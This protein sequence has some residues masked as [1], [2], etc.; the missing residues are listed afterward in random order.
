MK[1][2]RIARLKQSK[3][4]RKVSKVVTIGLL[5]CPLTLGAINALADTETTEPVTEEVTPVEETPATN[6]EIAPV[7]GT[8][9][10]EPSQSE[11]IEEIQTEES[12]VIEETLTEQQTIETPVLTEQLQE[13]TETSQAV[14]I[15][16][17]YIVSNIVDDNGN[18]I[19]TRRSPETAVKDS[20]VEIK[21][22]NWYGYYL[23]P[24]TPSEY[25]AQIT[26]DD[27]QEFV[28]TY[29]SATSEKHRDPV[30]DKQIDDLFTELYSLHGELVPKAQ[31]TEF[32]DQLQ[33]IYYKFDDISHIQG[34]VKAEGGLLAWYEYSLPKLPSILEE[35]KSLAEK[36]N[37]LQPETPEKTGTYTVECLAVLPGDDFQSVIFTEVKTAPYGTTIR[38]DAPEI[39]GYKLWLN[40]GSGYS[41]PFVNFTMNEEQDNRKVIF[42]YLVDDS[43]SGIVLD[44]ESAKDVLAK[45][46]A[47]VQSNYT[48]ESW[49]NLQDTIANDSEINWISGLREIIIGNALASQENVDKAV[50]TV[51]DAIS[52]LVEVDPISLAEELAQLQVNYDKH[53]SLNESDYTPESWGLYTSWV[54][55]QW[56]LDKG[57]ET[58]LSNPE[59]APG[60]DVNGY[61]ILWEQA[62]ALLVAKDDNQ[63][64]GGDN[65]DNSNNGGNG[66]D[67]TDNSNNQNGNTNQDENNNNSSNPSNTN[68]NTNKANNQTATNNNTKDTTDLPQTGDT[69][70]NMIISG[71]TMLGASLIAIL[72]RGRKKA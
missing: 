26:Q 47:L 49:K 69:P 54:Y 2:T 43:S 16:T 29:M 57:T 63:N 48:V 34:L 67:T 28:F 25:S 58:I 42:N 6:E 8:E 4:V 68:S 39:S 41:N 62:F 70:T 1:N 44:L 64:N 32:E 55:N 40:F 3:R 66:T 38:E 33:T 52:Q 61:N 30:K 17:Y 72:V 10:S 14:E 18:I 71:L 24:G 27:T 45:Y 19:E 20:T 31:G 60:Y 22:I 36:I 15:Y 12:V 65:T 37:A 51:N 53:N 59:L 7:E 56:F 46:D 9:M 5:V 21:A 13:D 11:T 50:K 23:L 35:L